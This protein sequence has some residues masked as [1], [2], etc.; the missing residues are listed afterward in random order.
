VRLCDGFEALE[1]LHTALCGFDNLPRPFIYGIALFLAIDLPLLPVIDF[2]LENL[3]EICAAWVEVGGE[4][5][6]L[7]AAACKAAKR[8][9]PKFLH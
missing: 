3:F 2:I 7:T 8:V 1:T 4:A 9:L 6:D 5:V